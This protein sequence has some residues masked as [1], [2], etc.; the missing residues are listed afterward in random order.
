MSLFAITSIYQQRRCRFVRTKHRRNRIDKAALELDG[1]DF[2]LL[3]EYANFLD[4]N[5]QPDKAGSILQPFSLF[6][7]FF[8]FVCLIDCVVVVF[9][10]TSSSRS[11]IGV[12]R[13]CPRTETYFMKAF[14]LNPNDDRIAQVFLFTTLWFFC[15][16]CFFRG[17]MM[18]LCGCYCC[19]FFFFFFFFLQNIG[20]FLSRQVR[21]F[22]SSHSSYIHNHS[23][24]RTTTILSIS[25]PERPN[26]RII[27]ARE[28]RVGWSK[29]ARTT[30]LRRQSTRSKSTNCSRTN[31]GDR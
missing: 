21:S 24:F 14:Y 11:S 29:R 16:C 28:Q 20:D 8:L 2:E 22:E 26:L 4:A 12:W 19:R 13:R 3:F 25:S 18:V 23:T 10:S 15:C 7:F 1:S 27:V 6:F 17:D 5:K 31:A 9:G 30:T